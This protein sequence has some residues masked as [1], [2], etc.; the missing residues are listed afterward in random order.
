M[1]HKLRINLTKIYKNQKHIH[2]R[3]LIKHFNVDF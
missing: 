3:M 2:F 1:I